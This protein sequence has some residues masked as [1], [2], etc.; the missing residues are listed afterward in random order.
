MLP[1]KQRLKI[2]D[3]WTIVIMIANFFHIIVCIILIYPKVFSTDTHRVADAL[4]GF[5]TFLNWISLTMYLQYYDEL[6]DLPFT[7][8]LT[9]LPIM[10]QFIQTFPVI[11]GFSF[12]CMATFGTNTRFHS[13]QRSV[14]MLWSLWNGDECQNMYYALLP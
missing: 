10:N 14:I 5:G 1:V 4:F 9:A 8:M 13:F 7:A 2:V 11:F 3:A 12:Y 6:N